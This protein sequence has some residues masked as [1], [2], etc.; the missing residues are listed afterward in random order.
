MRRIATLVAALSIAVALAAVPAQAGF[1]TSQLKDAGKEAAVKLKDG[2][3]HGHPE[4]SFNN[5]DR[6]LEPTG[7]GVDV[8]AELETIAQCESGGDY[9]AVNSSSGAAG[10]YQFLPSTWDSIADP[11]WVGVN[12]ADAPPAVQDE[13]AVR[14][15]AGGA[16]RSHWVC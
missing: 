12:P 8:P 2:G 9:T 3:A 10:K 16:G 11:E 7:G 4:P 15:Y 1:I 5:P 14:L 13:M 6:G